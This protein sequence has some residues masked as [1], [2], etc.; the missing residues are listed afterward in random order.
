M[1]VTR[2]TT[3]PG[4]KNSTQGNDIRMQWIQKL[5]KQLAFT[6]LISFSKISASS[7]SAKGILANKSHKYYE[8]SS[9]LRLL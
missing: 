4:T 9:K 8:N 6:A 5:E 2:S 7:V 1:A 3:N